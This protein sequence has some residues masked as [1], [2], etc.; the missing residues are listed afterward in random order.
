MEL[1][2]FVENTLIA[3]ARGVEAAHK[4]APGV[5]PLLEPPGEGDDVAGLIFTRD[6][7]NLQ[8]VFMVDFDVAVSA[9][10]KTG[11]EVGGGIRVL[12]FISGTAKRSSDTHDS[13]VSRIKF[14]I[15][16]R[17]TNNEA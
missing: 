11:S 8:P 9:D 13:T 15:P 14:K 4:A 6:G 7:G 10:K 1:Q 16:L 3:I 12:E 17:L 2:T 5:A